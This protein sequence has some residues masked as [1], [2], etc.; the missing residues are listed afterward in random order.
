MNDQFVNHNKVYC[1]H[2][3][4]LFIKKWLTLIQ[5]L[6]KRKN[7]QKKEKEGERIKNHFN[8]TTFI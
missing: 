3:G 7:K 5:H 4:N 2:R 8:S 1:P 6:R